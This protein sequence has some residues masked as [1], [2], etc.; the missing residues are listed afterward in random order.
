MPNVRLGG[1]VIDFLAQNAR[2]VRAARRNVNALRRQQRAVFRLKRE[3]RAFN[4]RAREMRRQILSVRGAVAL[5]AGASGLGLLARRFI[6]AG[7]TLTRLQAQLRLVTV[8]ETTPELAVRCAARIRA[9]GIPG[10]DGGIENTQ[11]SGGGG[12][13]ATGCVASGGDV[14]I[15]GGSAAGGDGGGNTS[16]YQGKS[17]VSGASGTDAIS[18]LESYGDGQG[19]TGGI[20]TQADHGGGGAGGAYVK[21]NALA[22]TPG[23]SIAYTVGAA[24]GPGVAGGAIRL[25]FTAILYAAALSGGALESAARLKVP[26]PYLAPLSTS[27]MAISA[28]LSGIVNPAASL[29]G[30]P[31]TVAARLTVPNPYAAR[32]VGGGWRSA[33]G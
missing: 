17:G 10:R 30:Q 14:N 4:R 28:R 1:L 25:T 31:L 7:D 16:P 6:E 32:L 8:S 21:V 20:G 22:V 5:L 29:T 27:S 12:G 23:D 33:R 3:V 24:G 18:G 2:L 15:N 19:G 26:N 13:G 11:Q 9:P